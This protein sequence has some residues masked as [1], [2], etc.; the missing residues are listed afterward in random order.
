LDY[1]R[2]EAPLHKQLLEKW[3]VSRRRQRLK[4][5]FILGFL[6]RLKP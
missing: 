4:P 2:T 3:N 5:F 1:K 6:S